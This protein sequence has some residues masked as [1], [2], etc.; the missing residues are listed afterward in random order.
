M[1]ELDDCERSAKIRLYRNADEHEHQ[2]LFDEYEL[3][4]IFKLARAKS[5]T[6]QTASAVQGG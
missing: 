6:V 1:P 4:I 3:Q 5:G 2:M